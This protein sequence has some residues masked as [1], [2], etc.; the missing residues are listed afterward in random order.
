MGVKVDLPHSGTVC[1]TLWVLRNI[2]GSQKDE[3]GGVWKRI[4]TEEFHDLYCSTNIVCVI[5]SSLRWAG[6][7][8]LM[9]ERRSAYR[10]LVKK[11]RGKE[12]NWKT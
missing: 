9:E 5:K 11:P 4:H 3:E 1:N 2:F 12:L 8:A 7:V 6:H 10:N